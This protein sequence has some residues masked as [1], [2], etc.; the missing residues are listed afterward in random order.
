MLSMRL[1]PG[2]PPQVLTV[3]LSLGS[4]GFGAFPYGVAS[5]EV[6]CALLLAGLDY[7][8]FRHVRTWIYRVPG[9]I[10]PIVW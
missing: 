7:I 10:R 4:F 1:A 8:T 3:A 2:T 9:G 5:C 6:S